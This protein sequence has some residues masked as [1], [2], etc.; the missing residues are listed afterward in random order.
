[1][2]WPKR[3]KMKYD[4]ARHSII[5]INTSHDIHNSA[6]FGDHFPTEEIHTIWDRG[7]EK[8]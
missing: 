8:K 6:K 3:K 5:S 7:S 4:V 1:M 2:I